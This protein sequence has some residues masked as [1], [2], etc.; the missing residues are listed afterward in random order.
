MLYYIVEAIKKLPEFV[1]TSVEKKK[2][3]IA[4]NEFEQRKK[5]R[6]SSNSKFVNKEDWFNEKEKNIKYNKPNFKP[7]VKINNNLATCDYVSDIF[8]EKSKLFNH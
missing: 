3:N 5:D 2:V 8:I 6:Q 7:K 4:N 1:N